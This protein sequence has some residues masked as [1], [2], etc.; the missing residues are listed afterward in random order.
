MTELTT[1]NLPFV[2]VQLA[3]LCN[4]ELLQAVAT[5]YCACNKIYNI[6]WSSRCTKQ[7]R[8][9]AAINLTWDTQS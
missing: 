5:M 8:Q 1:Y 3:L 7:I 6:G 2:P 4:V 9:Q